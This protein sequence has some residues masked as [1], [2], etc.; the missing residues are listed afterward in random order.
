MSLI[1]VIIT[2]KNRLSYLQKAIAS[3]KEQTYTNWELIIVNDNSTDGTTE[4]LANDPTLTAINISKSKGG[5]HA[6]NRGIDK[7]QGEYVAFLDDDDQW[8]PEKLELQLEKIN[9]DKSHFCDCGLNVYRP[10]DT[11]VKY[12]LTPMKYP[13]DN[14]K[15]IMYNSFNGSTSGIMVKRSTILEV[16]GF[17]EQIYAMQEYDLA[18]RLMYRGIKVSRVNKPLVK[19]L[20]HNETTQVSTSFHKYYRSARQMLQKYKTYPYFSLLQKRI[21]IIGIKKALKSPYFTR[22][23]LLHLLGL[24]KIT[25]K[26]SSRNN[27]S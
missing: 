11:F 20:V 2:T 6:R 13:N 26:K 15:S 27:N 25:H 1:S 9:R 3:V 10:D 23:A 8:Y 14:L 12:I 4:Y 21:F 17:D 16:G 7:V 22:D 5:N 18:I 24:K 19:Y